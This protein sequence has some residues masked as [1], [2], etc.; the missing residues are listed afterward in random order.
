MDE[1]ELPLDEAVLCP[2][3]HDWEIADVLQGVQHLGACC[4]HLLHE[5][6]GHGGRF[7]ARMH[8]KQT[9]WDVETIASHCLGA[10]CAHFWWRI[11]VGMLDHYEVIVIN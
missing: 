4:P 10:V 1:P 7:N 3:C 9:L 6:V 8:G 2:F 5:Q 11:C